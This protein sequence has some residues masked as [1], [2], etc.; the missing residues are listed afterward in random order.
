MKQD[1]DLER[2]HV[3][4]MAWLLGTGSAAQGYPP[5]MG[6]SVSMKH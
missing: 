2:G 6:A 4:G 1:A 3:P 5:S